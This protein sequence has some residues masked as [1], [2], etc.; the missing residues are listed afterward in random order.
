ML[1]SNP[2]ILRTCTDVKIG[3]VKVDGEPLSFLNY[4]G[5]V[6]TR[7]LKL[8]IDFVK[9]DMSEGATKSDSVLDCLGL[10]H[11]TLH[12]TDKTFPSDNMGLVEEIKNSEEFQNWKADIKYRFLNTHLGI[13]TIS[14]P[15]PVV[16]TRHPN[17]MEET[18]ELIKEEDTL[19]VFLDGL[20]ATNYIE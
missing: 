18:I 14:T 11:R 7:L 3:G 6:E 10:I 1:F 5:A 16:G 19:Q 13:V 15:I 17:I 9:E 8:V 2:E 4:M 20:S 12:F